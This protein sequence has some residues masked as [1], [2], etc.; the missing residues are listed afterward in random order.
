MSSRCAGSAQA[1]RPQDGCG[2]AHRT[3]LGIPPRS[4]RAGR[5]TFSGWPGA[6]SLL[7][8]AHHPDPLGDGDGVPR[9]PRRRIRPGFPRP[10]GMPFGE[11][12]RTT[13]T[14]WS[15]WIPPRASQ[16]RSNQACVEWLET[17]PNTNV[18]DRRW[19]R[20]KFSKGMPDRG[21]HCGP[22][23]ALRSDPVSVQI[24]HERRHAVRWPA[25]QSQLQRKRESAWRMGRVEF[26]VGSLSRTVAQP[27]SRL[28]FT[29]NP[30]R[31][32][33]TVFPG[34]HPAE[35]HRSRGR[36]QDGWGCAA[37]LR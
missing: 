8:A 11:V 30:Y 21:H 15:A 36:I 20:M 16:D 3:P 18:R 13:L 28:G 23:A 32:E 26:P 34:D 1:C 25:S 33:E 35:P 7:S 31:A 5:G 27:S 14:S 22:R 6:S 9:V 19:R 24:D 10:C 4:F 2:Q 37:Y 29:F 12:E 17:T